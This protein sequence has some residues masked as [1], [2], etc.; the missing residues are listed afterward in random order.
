MVTYLSI[1][2]TLW[3]S[4]LL[5]GLI[6]TLASCQSVQDYT[7]PLSADFMSASEMYQANKPTWRLSSSAYQQQFGVFTIQGAD[8]S[9]KTSTKANLWFAESGLLDKDEVNDSWLKFI[10]A[11]I[12]NRRGHSIENYKIVRHQDFAFELLQ[13]G[14]PSVHSQCRIMALDEGTEIRSLNTNDNSQYDRT[15]RKHSYMGCLVSQGNQIWQLIADSRKGEA[16]YFDMT[17]SNLQLQFKPVNE[18]LMLVNQQYISMPEWFK[19][20]SGLTIHQQGLQLSALSFDGDKPK[21]WLRKALP[22]AQ[23]ALLLTASY[24]LLMYDWLDEEWRSPSL[25]MPN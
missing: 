13:N 12:L 10:A 18:K 4:I 19:Q 7:I 25:K 23:Q 11:D 14:Q 21:I 8:V 22:T 2:A 17:S 9:W 6:S 16:N 5:M 15:G 20:Q 24:S 1:S 3:R